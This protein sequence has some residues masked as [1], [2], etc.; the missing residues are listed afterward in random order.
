MGLPGTCRGQRLACRMYFIHSELSSSGTGNNTGTIFAGSGSGGISFT[1]RHG[2]VSV[3]KYFSMVC[4]K[5]H[6]KWTTG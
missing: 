6:I 4:V 2:V 5:F 3:G 1:G